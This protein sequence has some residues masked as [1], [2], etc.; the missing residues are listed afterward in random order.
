[1]I[2]KS[3]KINES[4]VSFFIQK[5]DNIPIVFLHGFCED[6]SMWND[7]LLDF[8]DNYLLCIDLPGFGKSSP[9]IGCSLQDMAS[10]VN[11]IIEK[12][13]IKKCVLIGHS[14][15]G[16][17]ALEF[18]KKY[19]EKVDGLGLFH[20][21]PFADSAAKKESRRKSID[22]IQKNGSVYFVKQLIPKLFAPRFDSKSSLTISKLIFASS[23]YPPDGIINALEAM[24][25]R[26]DNADVLKQAS[27]PVLFIVGAEDITIPK[28]NCF[29]QLAFPNISKIH[30]LSGVGHMGMFEAKPA[31]ILAVKNFIDFACG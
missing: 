11:T 30:V 1:M 23:N 18:A 3:Y 29:D 16:Y 6:S 25:N 26:V 21:Q 13:D 28:E 5:R 19:P 15:G 4:N 12:I 22:F 10:I 24:I 20:S 2:Q 8:P 14:M 7:F 31:C 17:V 27:F 9:Q